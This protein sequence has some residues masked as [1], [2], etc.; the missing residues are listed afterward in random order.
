MGDLQ[1][2]QWSSSFN[3]HIELVVA[4]IAAGIYYDVNA[5]EFM[6]YL[7]CPQQPLDLSCNR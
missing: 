4:K 2:S 6:Q 3:K 5:Q 1:T 7:F